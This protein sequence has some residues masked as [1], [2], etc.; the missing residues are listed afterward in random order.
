[1]VARGPL[2]SGSRR[3]TLE[4][5]HGDD[6]LLHDLTADKFP[7]LKRFKAC[8]EFA[9]NAV[10]RP[11]SEVVAWIALNVQSLQCLRARADEGEAAV[12]AGVDQLLGGWRRG[13]EDAQPA[14]L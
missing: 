12:M 10:V 2:A 14:E 5:A 7:R 3:S 13:D 1:M 6:V 8:R 9:P 4:A 11:E